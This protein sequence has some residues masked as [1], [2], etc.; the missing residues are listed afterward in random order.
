[1]K[2]IVASDFLQQMRLAGHFSYAIQ[3]ITPFQ[4]QISRF[5][6]LLLYIFFPYL[7]KTQYIYGLQILKI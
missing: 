3:N 1:M 6:V 7:V 4:F 2:M 5:A